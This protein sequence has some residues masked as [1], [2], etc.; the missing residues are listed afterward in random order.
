MK[1][2][3]LLFLLGR[4][5][6]AHWVFGE[7]CVSQ[8]KGFAVPVPNRK[9]EPLIPEILKYVLPGSIIISDL[10]KGYI[11]LSRYGYIHR[12]VNHSTNFVDPVSGACTNGVEG[13]WSNLKS[14]LKSIRG[15]QGELKFQHL[16]EIVFRKNMG[17]CWQPRLENFL[18]PYL[19]H[20]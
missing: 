2:L 5:V 11:S 14:K 8:R 15:S 20:S 16:A 6:E 12:T 18:R 1:C 7:Y 9:A 10:W 17:W 3:S 4:L 13:M 19:D